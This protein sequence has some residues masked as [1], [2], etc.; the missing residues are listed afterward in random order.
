MAKRASNSD[1]GPAWFRGMR[2]WRL[3][4]PLPVPHS[5]NLALPF[6]VPQTGIWKWLFKP[7]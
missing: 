2:M 1:W 4:Q 5:P 3:P 7:A 6:S